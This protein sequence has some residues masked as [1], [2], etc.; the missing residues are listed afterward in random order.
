MQGRIDAT[1]GFD[2]RIMSI[3]CKSAHFSPLLWDGKVLLYKAL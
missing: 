3:M 1:S 2:K